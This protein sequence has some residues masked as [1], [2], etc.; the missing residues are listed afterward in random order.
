MK[1]VLAIA[2]VALTVALAT[3]GVA[4]LVSVGAGVAGIAAAFAAFMSFAATERTNFAFVWAELFFDSPDPD[5]QRSRLRVQLH[6]DGPGIALDVRWSIG[7][8][9]ESDRRAY[10]Q[11]EEATADSATSVVRALRPGKSHPAL[12]PDDAES[13]AL[14]KAHYER[15]ARTV[16]REEPWWVLVRWSDSAGRRWE[17]AEASAG[18]RARSSSNHRSRVAWSAPPV[19][20]ADDPAVVDVD[21]ASLGATTPAARLVKPLAVHTQRPVSGCR[22][23]I[24]A[25]RC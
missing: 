17:F 11:A 14:A 15:T 6:S 19:V 9:H 4:E 24:S 16:D 22:G 23:T 18:P 2:V 5:S 1:L 25:C 3:H 8:P 7:E 21:G 20:G 10:R 13:D 12:A